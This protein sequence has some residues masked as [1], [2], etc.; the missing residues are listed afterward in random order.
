[1]HN[2]A[3]PEIIELFCCNIIT[4]LKHATTGVVPSTQQD[5]FKHWWDDDLED[6]KQKSIDAHNIW[7]SC[8]RP[9]SGDVYKLKRNAKATYKLA[10]RNKRDDESLVI[11]NTLNDCLL[12]KDN[13][14]FWNTWRCKFSKRDTSAK[15][16][17]G[18]SD[19]RIIVNK[20]AD[21][22]KSV[23]TPNSARGSGKLFDEFLQLYDNYIQKYSNNMDYNISPELVA[24]CVCKLKSK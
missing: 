5:F 17:D 4:G 11:S 18:S 23:C 3:S 20:F 19:D 8:G 2:E 13:Q 16:I 12:M 22:F 6:L 9:L 10:I 1:M 14:S 21:S 24:M 15:F 7:I